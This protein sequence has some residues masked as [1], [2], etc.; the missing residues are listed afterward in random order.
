[1]PVTIRVDGLSQ[2]GERMRVLETD[3]ADRV[4][5]Q[6]V[7]AAAQVVKKGVQ[8]KMR[9][10][11][12]VETGLMVDNVITKK[13]P[14]SQTQ[15]AAEYVVTERKK[16]YP[17]EGKQKTRRDTKQVARYKEFGTVKMA[18]EPAFRPGFEE[19]KETAVTA[20]AERLADR[21]TKAGA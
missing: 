11:P 16:L 10:N 13:L 2:L 9:T 21:I 6:A 19:T 12:D 4:S 18:A 3:I 7:A 15:Y 20:M 8:G 1:M 5:R 14:K 17:L